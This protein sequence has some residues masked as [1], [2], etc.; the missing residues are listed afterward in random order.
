MS[1]PTIAPQP[2]LARLFHAPAALLLSVGALLGF[3]FPLGKL[4]AAAG[5]PPLVWATLLSGGGALVLA[6]ALLMK[7]QATRPTPQLMRYFVIVAV[8]SYA[9]PNV[10]IFT[11][12]PHLGSAYAAIVF[13]LSPMFTV[14][15]S[16]LARLRAPRRL[17]FAGIVI[18]FIGTLLVASGRGEVGRPVEW[19]WVA[20]VALVPVSLALGNVYRTIDL[21]RGAPT[22][23][24]AVG[25]NAVAALLLLLLCGL[26]GQ[27]GDFARLATVP[28]LV[29]L[30]I[31]AT[32][33]MLALFFQ[34]QVVGGP[35]TLSQIGTVAAGVGVLAGTIGLGERY[36]AIVWIGIAIIAVGI[37][38]TVRARM[39]R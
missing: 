36:P 35:V 9:L 14:I 20:L 15:F 25:S 2:L 30:Q 32:A 10:L 4:A 11:A 7:R 33:A 23:V 31:A 17:E 5:I 1:N 28:G 29:A 22:L 37:S 24:L 6:V 27:L 8:V 26:T 18:G 21:P 16:F 39:R 19:F 12:I 34:L 3:T 13:T 38:L